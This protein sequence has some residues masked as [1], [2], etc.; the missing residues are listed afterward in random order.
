MLFVLQF[1]SHSC[2]WK[3]VRRISTALKSSRRAY[4]SERCRIRNALNWTQV[5]V[6]T[7]L[8]LPCSCLFV[9]SCLV[10]S[11]LLHISFISFSQFGSQCV[12]KA[13]DSSTSTQ[14][15]VKLAERYG[16]DHFYRGA[17]IPFSLLVWRSESRSSLFC[18][19]RTSSVRLSSTF[20]TW[21]TCL[22]FWSILSTLVWLLL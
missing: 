19:R 2:S 15:A 1:V 18:W 5:W 20:T 13:M 22:S 16:L 6:I 9:F 4:W 8:L 17:I 14:D 21:S 3:S 11:F 10:Y 7:H 12:G